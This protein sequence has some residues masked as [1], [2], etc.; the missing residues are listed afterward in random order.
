MG[1][2]FND[3]DGDGFTDI[4]VANDN[5]P[6]S[7]F[8]NIKGKSF[9]EVALDVGVAYAE[10]GKA[11]SGMGV[12]L[13]DLDNDGL[14]DVW[15]TATEL[16]T[17]PLFRNIGKGM[18]VDFTG[19]SGL[20]RSTLEMSGWGNAV[21]DFD[22]DGLKDLLVARGNVLDNIAD[23]SQRTWGEPLSVFRNLGN[24]KFED[25]SSQCG[26]ALQVKE[27]YRGCVI[28]DLFNSGRLDVVTTALS[29]DARILRNVTSNP[30][31]WVAFRLV[32]TKSN[33]MGIGAQL[34]L[35]TEDGNS[36]YD[37]VSTSAGYQ[38]SRDHR[39]HFGLGPFKT[40]KQLEIRWPS[41]IR[42]VLKN[43][44]GN[45]IQSVEETSS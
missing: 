41:G 38:A 44:A 37:I 24:M 40:V 4:F 42:Q 31:N 8:R 3:F 7:L 22:N 16:E 23:F 19:R 34:K 33:R 29:S 21:A 30:N 35:T 12:E 6:N 14:P 1:V 5:M 26:A 39:A 45:Q 27:P 20:A 13:R 2:A 9:E 15:H 32:G 11:V 25:I 43:L 10:T 17:F 18:F 28:G 36:Q